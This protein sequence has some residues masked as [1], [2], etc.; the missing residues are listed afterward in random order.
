L[1]DT[2]TS[3]DQIFEEKELEFEAVE[4]ENESDESR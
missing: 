4:A 3:K 2:T 1:I